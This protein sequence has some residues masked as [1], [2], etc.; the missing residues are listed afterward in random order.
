MS[1]SFSTR[2]GLPSRAVRAWARSNRLQPSCPRFGAVRTTPWRTAPGKPTEMRSYAGSGATSAVMVSTTSAGMLS[3][4]VGTR[5]RSVRNAPV[6]SSTEAL[7]WDPPT[8]M[9]SVC[10]RGP[11]V[12]AAPGADVSP[13]GDV[14][15]L[16]FAM[17]SLLRAAVAAAPGSVAAEASEEPGWQEPDEAA[18]AGRLPV[19]L[20]EGR[21]TLP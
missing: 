17:D 8:S 20:D 6:E 14:T 11:G 15:A 1:A 2:V 7:M 19:E 3:S 13:V 18:L 10:G 12:V 21:R 16:T 5:T 9:A 4:G